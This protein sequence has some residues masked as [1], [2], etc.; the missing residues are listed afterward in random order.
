MN[1]GKCIAPMQIL[2]ILETRGGAAEV[3]GN[4]VI[5]TQFFCT[6]KTSSKNKV[7]WFE[8]VKSKIDRAYGK[9]SGSAF[10]Y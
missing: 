10:F 2:I 5:S 8:K 4:S 9:V 3:H 6:S 7:Y 1:W